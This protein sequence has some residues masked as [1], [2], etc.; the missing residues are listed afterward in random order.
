[1]VGMIKQWR[2]WRWN[3]KEEAS[4]SQKIIIIDVVGIKKLLIPYEFVYGKNKE[5]DGKYFIRHKNGKKKIDDYTLSFHRWED[6][7]IKSK[8]HTACPF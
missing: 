1:M 6:F 8:E 7:F 5:T 4:S 2:W 3:W